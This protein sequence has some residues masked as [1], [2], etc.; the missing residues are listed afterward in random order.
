PLGALMDDPVI[1]GDQKASAVAVQAARASVMPGIPERG[2][3]RAP[4]NASLELSGTGKHE[5]TTAL[6]NAA[7]QIT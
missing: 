1:K 7:K 2:E 3:V 4:A 6:D 5:P